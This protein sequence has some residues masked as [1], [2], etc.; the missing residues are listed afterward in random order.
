MAFDREHAVT[1]RHGRVG[2]RDVVGLVTTDEGFRLGQRESGADEWTT[3]RDES[4]QHDAVIG[5]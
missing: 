4:E 3:D 5:R 2:E 1:R